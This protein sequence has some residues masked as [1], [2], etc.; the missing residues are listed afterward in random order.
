MLIVVVVVVVVVDVV[1]VDVVVVVVVVVVAVVVVVVAVVAVVLKLHVAVVLKLHVAI[2][3]NLI[4]TI[5]HILQRTCTSINRGDGFQHHHNQRIIRTTLN[6][7][8]CGEDERGEVTVGEPEMK[9]VGVE[10]ERGLDELRKQER[11][12]E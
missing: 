8:C 3:A 10:Q 7:D 2:A 11:W 6:I 12:P 1:V 5:N 4:T 9:V